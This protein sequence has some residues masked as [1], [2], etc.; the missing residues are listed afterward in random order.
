[1]PINSG[2][3]S[4]EVN[5]EH[6]ADTRD[7]ICRIMESAAELTVALKVQTGLGLNWDEAH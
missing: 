4:L 6:A 1:M 7:Q 2:H 5:E 3:F